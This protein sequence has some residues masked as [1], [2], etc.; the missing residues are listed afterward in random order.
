MSDL[1]VPTIWSSIAIDDVEFPVFHGTTRTQHVDAWRAVDRALQ[2]KFWMFGAIAFSLVRKPGVRSDKYDEEV[3]QTEIQKFIK[4]VGIGRNTFQRVQRTY[5]V[6]A[7]PCTSAGTRYL[8]LL[9]FTHHEVAA[10]LT[11]STEDAVAAV[12]KAYQLRWSANRLQQSLASARPKPKLPVNFHKVLKVFAHLEMFINALPADTKRHVPGKLRL[13][14]RN[15]EWSL[16]PVL[17]RDRH[18]PSIRDV[19]GPDPLECVRDLVVADDDDLPEC[20]RE[21][22]T[23]DFSDPIGLHDM[24]A[25]Q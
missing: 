2:K 9:S 4:S 17:E 13:L 15:V 8:N 11:D 23:A 25:V 24:E 1:D 22:V 19:I 7:G 14:C 5:R 12:A 16:L 3:Y 21:F 10:R 6:F 18:P 20:L